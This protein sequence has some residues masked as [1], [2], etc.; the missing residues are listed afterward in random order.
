MKVPTDDLNVDLFASIDEDDED[1]E[2]EVGENEGGTTGLLIDIGGTTND[3]G[4]EAMDEDGTVAVEDNANATEGKADVEDTVGSEDIVVDK[5]N[6][7]GDDY[8][9]RS[10]SGAET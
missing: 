5:E 9:E 3:G 2:V 1:E 4:N 10:D 6:D 7:G 8:S